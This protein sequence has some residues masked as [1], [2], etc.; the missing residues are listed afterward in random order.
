VIAISHPTIVPERP[1][2]GQ[3]CPPHP[4]GSA[5]QLHKKDARCSENVAIIEIVIPDV[6][7]TSLKD[8]LSGPYDRA[9][10]SVALAFATWQRLT[11]IEGLSDEQGTEVMA[12]A[13]AGTLAA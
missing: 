9:T 7:E 4:R 1:G 2:G 13:V 6:S 5:T 8:L 3:W 10:V 12:R 11:T